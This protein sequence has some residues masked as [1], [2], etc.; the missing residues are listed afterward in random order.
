M[1]HLH[2]QSQQGN[3][4][5]DFINVDFLAQPEFLG[6][7]QTTFNFLCT[8]NYLDKHP[9]SSSLLSLS[10][11]AY[12]TGV[13]DLGHDGNVAEDGLSEEGSSTEGGGQGEEDE[14]A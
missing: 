10:Y 4:L 6:V 3:L 14:L 9:Q 1:L 5:T 8:K 11:R 2:P 12:N 13:G 7:K